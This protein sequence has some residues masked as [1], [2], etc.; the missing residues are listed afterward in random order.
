MYC[1]LQY[2]NPK[3]YNVFKKDNFKLMAKIFKKTGTR[4][5]KAYLNYILYTG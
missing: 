1:T 5:L 2:R 4:H 3:H